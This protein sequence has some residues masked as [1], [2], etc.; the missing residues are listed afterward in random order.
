MRSDF[1]YEGDDPRT[2]GMYMIWP[3]FESDDGVPLADAADIPVTGFA[4]MWILIFANFIEKD[5]RLV[6]GGVHD[7]RPLPDRRCR[8]NRTHRVALMIERE[9]YNKQLQRTVERHRGDA[10]R[11]PFHYARAAR[12]KPQCAA[13]ELRC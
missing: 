12:F 6:C 1:A 11:A 9:T 4:S 13:A 8:G 2:D 3:E 7:G 10:A 5:S